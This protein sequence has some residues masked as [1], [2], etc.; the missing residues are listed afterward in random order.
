LARRV[1]TAG[2]LDAALAAAVSHGELALIQAVV[3]TMDVPP[4]LESLAEAASAAN[5]RKVG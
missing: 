5:A 1:R 3:P 4:L 2:E